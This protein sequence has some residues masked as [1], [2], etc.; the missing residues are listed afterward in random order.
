MPA[1]KGE[2][3]TDPDSKRLK[4]RRGYVQGYNAQAVVDEGQ[5]VLAAEITNTHVDWS[6][7]DPMVHARS[8]S[9][10][11]RG[12]PSGRRSRSRTLSTGT[13]STWTR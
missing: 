13:N 12:R 10:S 11:G 2:S 6:N 3:L 7:L 5:I 1:G 9:S 8:A 4:A